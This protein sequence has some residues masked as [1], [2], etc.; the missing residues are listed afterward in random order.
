MRNCTKIGKKHKYIDQYEL[1]HQFMDK[2]PELWAIDENCLQCKSVLS[3]LKVINDLAERGVALVQ[4]YN[5]CLT[6]SEGQKQ[7]LLQ[8]VEEHRK[9][10]PDVTK[11]KVVTAY[12]NK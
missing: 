10:F 2:D 1:P 11:N 6:R 3:D 8:V 4:D 9:K 7:Y 12:S 5:N